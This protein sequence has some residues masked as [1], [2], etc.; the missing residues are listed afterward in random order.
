MAMWQ[1]L[2]NHQE[3]SKIHSLYTDQFPME[4]RS[5]CAAWIEEQITAEQC[6]DLNHPQIEKRAADF[7]DELRH[8]LQQKIASYK[9]PEDLPTKVRLEQ[10]V[11]TTL[12]QCNLFL[13]YKKVRYTLE[14][15]RKFVDNL[16]DS[17]WIESSVDAESEALEIDRLLGQ[18]MQSTQMIKKCCDQFVHVVEYRGIYVCT[19]RSEIMRRLE[20]NPEMEKDR[21][22]TIQM[23]DER[24][25]N[26]ELYITKLLTMLYQN[27]SKNVIIP[28]D[29]VQKQ[30][31]DGRLGRWQLNQVLAGNGAPLA[32]D[33]LNE[34]DEIQMWFK[35]LFDM[36]WLTRSV[37]IK[38]QAIIDKHA[39][40]YAT[41]FDE[42]L[43]RT[44]EL[45]ETLILA[46]FV[47]EKQPPQVIKKN[48]RYVCRVLFCFG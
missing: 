20:E 32:K 25:W 17:M 12:A 46:G 10:A 22:A 47:V 40:N 27:I 42:S 31:I 33:L 43:S 6:F 39:L 8:Q 14:T 37:I 3:F 28:I 4:V 23:C 5:A 38:I 24:Q 2:I 18:L 21:A 16:N 9:R 34:L 19:E 41:Q 13:L 35:K 7:V 1:R 45:L 26:M 36:I 15:E 44:K 11:D 29:V 48:T 30:V